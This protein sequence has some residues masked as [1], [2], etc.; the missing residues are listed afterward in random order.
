[1]VEMTPEDIQNITDAVAKKMGEALIAGS[2]ESRAMARGCFRCGFRGSYSCD[3]DPFECTT[4]FRCG[5]GF[6]RV[7]LE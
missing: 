1:M 2:P 7:V 6:T 4:V 5:G 3:Q